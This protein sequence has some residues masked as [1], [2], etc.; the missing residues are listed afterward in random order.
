MYSV[1]NSINVRPSHGLIAFWRL[2]GEVTSPVQ[3]KAAGP[4]SSGEFDSYKNHELY[5]IRWVCQALRCFHIVLWSIYQS[6]FSVV[7]I[8]T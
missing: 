7:G 1:S 6:Q 2:T 8:K 4:I 3:R 5:M